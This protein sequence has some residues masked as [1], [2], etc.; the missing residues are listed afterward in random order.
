MWKLKLKTK[1]RKY[2]AKKMLKTE[3]FNKY[4]AKMSSFRKSKNEE[5]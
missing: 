3:N 4:L 1:E 5:I 2:Y